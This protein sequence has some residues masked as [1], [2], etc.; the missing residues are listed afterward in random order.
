MN[1]GDNNFLPSSRKSINKAIKFAI[2]DFDIVAL[3]GFSP[4]HSFLWYKNVLRDLCLRF[5]DTR[6]YPHE[7]NDG[8][9]GSFHAC[10]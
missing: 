2:N 10:I 4:S 7:P 5:A 3:N 6:L 8:G 1:I 9:G